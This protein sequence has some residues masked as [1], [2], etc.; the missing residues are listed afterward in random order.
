MQQFPV[1]RLW[2]GTGYLVF[3]MANVNSQKGQTVLPEYVVV[4][5]VVIVAMVAITVYIRRALQARQR[6]A[7]V[8]MID[9][10]AQGCAQADLNSGGS[11]D[12]QGAAGINGGR[13][14]YDYEPYYSQAASNV[15]RG[16][17]EQTALFV[18]SIFHKWSVGQT[19]V[20]TA[21]AQS[22]PWSAN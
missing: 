1:P 9:M 4:F 13:F 2:R 10:A 20:N 7:K 11:L 17:A 19:Q 3:I 6:D 12:C 18:N 8:Y 5:F 21:S 16:Q 22:P 14:I 15:D